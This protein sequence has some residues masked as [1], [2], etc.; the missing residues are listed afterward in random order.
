MGFVQFYPLSND[1][2]RIITK[3]PQ[4]IKLESST[5]TYIIR[6]MGVVFIKFGKYPEYVI[7][8]TNQH[9][10]KALK[11]ISVEAYNNCR[12]NRIKRWHA[13]IGSAA[14]TEY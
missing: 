8:S 10:L 4:N 11:D 12:K 13:C 3:R 6:N 14:Y 7:K 5:W 1:I 9:S 2:R